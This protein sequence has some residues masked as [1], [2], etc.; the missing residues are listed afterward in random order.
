MIGAHVQEFGRP[1]VLINNAGDVVRRSGFEQLDDDLIDY[2][3]ALNA[4]AVVTACRLA[5]PASF[6]RA[7]ATSSTP[8]R[9]PRA[10]RAD[11]GLRS[12]PR[13]KASP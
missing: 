10:R 12:I 7:E 13:A 4:R 5:G 6:A 1:D 9:A 11:R 8:P 2:L 3:I